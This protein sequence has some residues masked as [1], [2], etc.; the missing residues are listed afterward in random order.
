MALFVFRDYWDEKESHRC[1][2]N[3]IH[4]LSDENLCLD[5]LLHHL[6][7]TDLKDGDEVKITITKTGKRPF[8]DRRYILQEPHRYGPETDKQMEERLNKSS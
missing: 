6:C 3:M 8:G 1:Y 2:R 7:P 4:N 5:D